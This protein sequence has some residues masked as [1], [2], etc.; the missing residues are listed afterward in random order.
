MIDIETIVFDHVYDAISELLPPDCIVSEYVPVAEKLPFVT[1]VE[2]ANVTMA[3]GQDNR[4]KE[5]FAV[6]AYDANV[7]ADTKEECRRIAIALDN[8]ML[9]MQFARVSPGMQ[10][11]TNMSDPLL[12]RMQ[13]RYEAVT[14]GHEI[15]RKP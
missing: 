14:D 7:Y 12:S 13:A 15:Y 2:I 8:A 11:I 9:E 6:I 4:L 5:N 10:Y 1:L 3:A